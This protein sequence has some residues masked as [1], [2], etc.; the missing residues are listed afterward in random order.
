MYFYGISRAFCVFFPLFL[1]HEAADTRFLA[2]VTTSAFAPHHPIGMLN[3]II[4]IVFVPFFRGACQNIDYVTLCGGG[5]D[6]AVAPINELRLSQMQIKCG[7][8]CCSSVVIAE[9]Q[10]II[11]R[12]YKTVIIICIQMYYIYVISSTIII[13]ALIIVGRSGTASRS[14]VE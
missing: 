5:G 6:S 1:A 8:R 3:S 9:I 14:V 11:A 2:L 10:I 7:T 12:V 13:S 4:I